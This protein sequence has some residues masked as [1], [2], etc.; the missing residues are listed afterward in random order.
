[1]HSCILV[2]SI[3]I[4]SSPNKNI[5]HCID[6]YGI[7]SGKTSD[8]IFIESVFVLDVGAAANKIFSKAICR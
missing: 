2:S 4:F 5:K 1:M 3:N 8:R 6:T 7:S